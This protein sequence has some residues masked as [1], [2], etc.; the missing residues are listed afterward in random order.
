MDIFYLFVNIYNYIFDITDHTNE[1]IIE[2]IIKEFE[3][4]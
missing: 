1:I 3:D 2:D 4:I